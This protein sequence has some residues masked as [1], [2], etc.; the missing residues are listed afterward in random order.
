MQK[1]INGWGYRETDFSLFPIVV[2]DETQRVW[3]YNNLNASRVRLRFSNRYGRKELPIEQVWIALATEQGQIDQNANVGVTFDGASGV[4]LKPGEVRYCDEIAFSANAGQ[5]VAVSLYIKK[6][7]TVTCATSSQSNIITRMSCERGGNYCTAREVIGHRFLG[8]AEAF[9][10]LKP[11]YNIVCCGLTQAEFLTDDNVTAVTVFGDSI[12][13][14]GHWS[15][16]LT[17]RLYEAAPGKVSVVNRGICG[18]RILHD[19]SVRSIYGRYFGEGALER[20]EEDVFETP[21]GTD[22][23]II[24]LQ[25]GINDII[26]PV[27]KT[28][29]QYEEISA[30]QMRDAYCSLIATAHAHGSKIYGCTLMPFRGFNEVWTEQ[31]E[32]LRREINQ[33]IRAK[34]GFDRVFDFAA[35]VCDPDASERLALNYNCGDNLHPNI[36]GGQALAERMDLSYFISI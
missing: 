36:A 23:D 27:D 35:V 31:T 32:A 30:G 2:E 14:H 28:C 9:L 3:F 18:N 10:E 11:R 34:A 6:K 26:Q 17:R 4:V 25:E 1:W 22:P 19:A 7:T 29:A 12:T 15:E 13:Q 5:W 33:M 20:F 21:A 8:D 24:V 16:A